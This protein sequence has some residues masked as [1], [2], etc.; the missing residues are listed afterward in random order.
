MKFNLLMVTLLL[1]HFTFAQKRSKAIVGIVTDVETIYDDAYIFESGIEKNHFNGNAFIETESVGFKYFYISDLEIP[2]HI[3]NEDD[4]DLVLYKDLSLEDSYYKGGQG[5]VKNNYVLSRHFF[6]KKLEAKP[7]FSKANKLAVVAR[8]I[9]VKDSMLFIANGLGLTEQFITDERFFWNT[10]LDYHTVFYNVLRLPVNSPLLLVPVPL[11]DYPAVDFL[12]EY[13]LDIPFYNILGYQYYIKE[14][15][16]AESKKD[17]LSVLNKIRKSTHFYDVL[18]YMENQVYNRSPQ[19]GIYLDLLYRDTNNLEVI[20]N[21]EEVRSYHRKNPLGKHFP[22]VY[23]RDVFDNAKLFKNFGELRTAVFLYAITD[24]KLS[25]NFLLWNQ[26]FLDTQGQYDNYITIC[27]DADLGQGYFTDSFKENPIAGAHLAVNY[28]VGQP[29]LEEIGQF[30]LPTVLSIEAT[31]EISNFNSL[32][33]IFNY[34]RI[35]NNPR[36]NRLLPALGA[37]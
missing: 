34:S 22:A 6:L 31:N 11:D 2:V 17:K 36:A 7:D 3:E 18:D 13:Y 27:I 26:F 15:D 12:N 21:L 35:Y 14:L 33:N 25:A 8:I 16:T 9:T 1:S 19:S 32:E 29:L 30:V 28:S 23:L 20:D 24:P 10:Y 37:Y 5:A 4:F